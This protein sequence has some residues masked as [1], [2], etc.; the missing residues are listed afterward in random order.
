MFVYS[1]PPPLPHTL[2]LRHAY[3]HKQIQGGAKERELSWE[4]VSARLQPATAGHAR[5]VLSKTVPF[6]CTSLYTTLL[7]YPDAPDSKASEW[8]NS[9]VFKFGYDSIAYRRHRP[10]EMHAS[11]WLTWLT[12]CECDLPSLSQYSELWLQWHW[13]GLSKMLV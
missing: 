6:F 3:L 8:V 9:S 2:K 1:F 11:D 7:A 10:I 13:W 5:L 4:K 12:H